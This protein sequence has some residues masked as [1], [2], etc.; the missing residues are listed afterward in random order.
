VEDDAAGVG[1]P[2]IAPEVLLFSIGTSFLEAGLVSVFLSS[3]AIIFPNA[4]LLD[5]V[6]LPPI[7]IPWPLG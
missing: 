5:Q 4:H 6:D 7:F 3:L 1:A 2:S